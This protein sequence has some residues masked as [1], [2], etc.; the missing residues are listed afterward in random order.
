MAERHVCGQYTMHEWG[1]GSGGVL[2]KISKFQKNLKFE[3]RKCHFLHS[4]HPNLLQKVK[5]ILTVIFL[6]ERDSP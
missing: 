4:E 3:S 6:L 1:G 2:A 5:K